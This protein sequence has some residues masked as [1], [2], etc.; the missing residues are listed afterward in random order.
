MK[1][2][3]LS[4]QAAD[5]LIAWAKFQHG[6]E[7]FFDGIGSLPA[8]WSWVVWQLKV[9]EDRP[10]WF[11]KGKWATIQHIEMSL[12]ETARAERRS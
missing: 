12:Y 10:A 11:P 1:L 6:D 7:L 5:G 3:Q 9:A 8:E 4:A 2:D